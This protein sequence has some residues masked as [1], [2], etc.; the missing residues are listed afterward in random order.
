ML[1]LHLVGEFELDETI[2]R[3]EIPW[4]FFPK[5]NNKA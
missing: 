1:P 3:H 4:E 2:E 5:F